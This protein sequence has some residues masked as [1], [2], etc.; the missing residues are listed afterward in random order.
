MDRAAI[1][2]L[3]IDWLD[4]NHHFG[5]AESLI[6]SDDISWIEHGILKSLAFVE[7]ILFLEDKCHVDLP[8][9]ELTRENFDGMNKILAKLEASGARL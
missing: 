1:R 3:I 7:L 6:V 9:A 2:Q 5:E 8:R 4:D